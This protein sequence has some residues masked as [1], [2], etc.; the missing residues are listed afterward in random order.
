MSL[1]FLVKTLPY[2]AALGLLVGAFFY[3]VNVGKGKQK[4]IYQDRIIEAG[5][6]H[7]EIEKEQARIIANRANVDV[8]NILHEGG[9]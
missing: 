6:R 4:I 1:S 3:G 5:E 7:V 8:I 9:F 2:L